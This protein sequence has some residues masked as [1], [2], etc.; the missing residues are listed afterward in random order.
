VVGLAEEGHGVV[1]VV[2]G[3]LGD[4]LGDPVGLQPVPAAEP[5]LRTPAAAD[6]ASV[7]M[8][9]LAI[10]KIHACRRSTTTTG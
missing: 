7:S 4:P 8:R 5:R 1:V 10:W 9:G 2:A 6:S 3:K